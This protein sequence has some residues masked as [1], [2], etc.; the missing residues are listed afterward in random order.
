MPGTVRKYSITMPRD[1]AEAARARSGLSGL[2]ACVAAD[3]ARQIE[4]DDLNDIIQAA[5]AEHGPVT[6]EEIHALRGRLHQARRE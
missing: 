4:R 5:E 3:V 6:D 1:V 2:S